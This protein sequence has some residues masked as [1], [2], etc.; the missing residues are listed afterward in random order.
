MSSSA[1][2][3][4]TASELSNLLANKEVSS[5]EIAQACLNQIDRVDDQ[6]H[7]FLH[8]DDQDFLAQARASD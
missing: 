3:E 1:L 8:R 2:V 4:K 6:V 5:V 7:A